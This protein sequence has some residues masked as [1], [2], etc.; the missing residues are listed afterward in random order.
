MPFIRRCQG[1]LRFQGRVVSVMLDSFNTLVGGS[2]NCQDRDGDWK[3]I[4]D[5]IK[6][7]L[8]AAGECDAN[9]CEGVDYLPRA[10]PALLA[11]SAGKAGR[12]S[13][14]ALQ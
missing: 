1:A 6:D 10:R 4:N 14:R 8:I 13:T 11:I 7:K 2:Y 3:R 9:G 12:I 5:A